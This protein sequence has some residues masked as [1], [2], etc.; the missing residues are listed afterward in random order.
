MKTLSIFLAL[1]AVQT[2]GIAQYNQMII[3]AN[4]NGA[5]MSALLDGTLPTELTTGAGYQSCYNGAFNSVDGRVYLSWYYGIYVMDV[6]GANFDTLYNYPAGGMGDGID[7][8]EANGH[9]YFTNSATDSIYRMN[10]DGTNLTPLYGGSANVGYLSALK[11]DVTN[12]HIYYGD[13]I[14]AVTGLFRLN[15]NGTN[16]TT[17]NNTTAPEYF[18]LDLTNGKIYYG[19]GQEIRRCNLNGTNDELLISG[20][21]CGG[22]A[23]DFPANRLYI[24]DMT[25]DRVLYADMT[26]WLTTDLVV[27]TDIYFGVDPLESPH[28]PILVYNPAVIGIEELS[29]DQSNEKELMMI[30]DF[31][32]RQTEFKPN[33]PLIYVYS[34]GTRE[35]VL[36]SDQ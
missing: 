33:V 15:M 35:R 30:V 24:T 1:F 21:Q 11:L 10:L 4:N 9:I 22:L 20:F 3:G 12:G 16:K 31:M 13:W 2:F 25:N 5:I 23:V 7:I 28:G 27:A 32:G 17:I 29:A 8:D 36:K 14:G 18:D 34:D 19:V 26:T 6:D